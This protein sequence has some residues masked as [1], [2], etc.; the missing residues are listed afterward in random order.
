ME[1]PHKKVKISVLAFEIGKSGPD[2][3][4][5]RAGGKCLPEKS[6]GFLYVSEDHS[7]RVTVPHRLG[8]VWIL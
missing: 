2:N 8:L 6:A 5:I 3:I 7:A 1:F 4:K